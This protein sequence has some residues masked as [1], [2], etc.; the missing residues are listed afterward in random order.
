MQLI[1]ATSFFHVQA[2]LMSI[3]QYILE[4]RGNCVITLCKLCIVQA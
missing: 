1:D 4:L 3:F 2:A